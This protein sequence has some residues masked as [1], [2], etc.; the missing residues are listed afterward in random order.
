MNLPSVDS[1][2]CFCAAAK[3]LNFRAA[4]RAVALT[5]AAFGQRIKQLEDQLGAQLF[6][7]TT[8]SVRLST[9]GLALLP[10]A[11]R[12]IASVEEC[13]RVVASEDALPPMELVIGT[14]HELGLSWLSPQIDHL[15]SLHPSLELHLYFG[16]GADL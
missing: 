15:K 3:F 13:A 11:Q 2:K 14:R 8:R 7:R 10:A 5:P 6:V 4:S 16:S 12:A 9:A 1:L